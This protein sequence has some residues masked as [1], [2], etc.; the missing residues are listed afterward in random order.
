MTLLGRSTCVFVIGLMAAAPLSAQRRLSPGMSHLP[1]D[2]MAMACAPT[3]AFEI[4]SPSLLITG[5]VD[6]FIRHSYGPGELITINAGT[7]NGIEVG[8]EYFVRRVQPSRQLTSRT[9]PATVKTAGWVRV[10][11]V[12]KTMSLVA[13][14]HT[15]DILN[16]GDY[17]EPFVLPRIPV[18][19]ANPPRPQ[20]ENYGHVMLGTD[21]RTMFSKDEFFVIDRGSDHGVTLGERV[22]LYRDKRQVEK[23][24]KSSENVFPKDIIPEFLYELGE[25][26]VIEVKPEIS[27]VKAIIARDAI[28]TGDLV[29]RRK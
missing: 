7:D 25:G 24:N 21:R 9:N 19:D 23:A 4:P 27:T 16:V 1:E 5:G 11:A 2:V 12:D 6:S 29:A 3:L 10:Y 8:Q 26:V 18:A 13:V 14:E 28:Q 20:R 15:C 22:I 17:L